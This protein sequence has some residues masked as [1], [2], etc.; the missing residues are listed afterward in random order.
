MTEMTMTNK[1]TT[2]KTKTT[3]ELES[4]ASTL[5]M[6]VEEIAGLITFLT[7]DLLLRQAAGVN[8]EFFFVDRK[9]EG[10]GGE[11]ADKEYYNNVE[12]YINNA[13]NDDAS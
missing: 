2:T 8:V 5:R 12:N 6:D 9:E 10:R 11:R 3:E 7:K 4:S 13:N 1:T